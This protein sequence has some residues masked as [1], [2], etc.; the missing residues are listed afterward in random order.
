MNAYL[1]VTVVAELTAAVTAAWR[2]IT[3]KTMDT[4]REMRFD[5]RFWPYI[6][7]TFE[8]TYYYVRT[9]VNIIYYIINV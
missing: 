6:H 7:R 1:L 5:V 8:R 9:F 4:G 2:Q 3:E